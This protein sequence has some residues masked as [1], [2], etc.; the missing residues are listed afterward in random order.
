MSK[1]LFTSGVNLRSAPRHGSKKKQIPDIGLPE[2]LDHKYLEK[3]EPRKNRTLDI[4]PQ[5][6][7]DLKYR[8]SVKQK[9]DLNFLGLTF[10]NKRIDAGQKCIR[11]SANCL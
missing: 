4:G 5:E 9:T 3:P 1:L 10:H 2:K 11:V 8:K 6:K 7:P